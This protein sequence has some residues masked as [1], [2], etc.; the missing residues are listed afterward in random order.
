MALRKAHIATILVVVCLVAGATAVFLGGR[1]IDARDREL[2]TRWQSAAFPHVRAA[3]TLH[4]DLGRVAGRLERKGA[5]REVQRI[6]EGLDDARRAL[7]EV[8]IPS[9][10]ERAAAAYLSG[11][12]NDLRALGFADDAVLAGSSR[13]DA[14]QQR[15]F[16]ESWQQATTHYGAGDRFLIESRCG[17]HMVACDAPIEYD[18]V[19]A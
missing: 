13:M 10:V 7:L 18:P 2:I 5:R 16:D 19:P 4:D 11:V 12:G 3:R 14:R 1:A 6:R 15:E 8:A 17:A 9:V